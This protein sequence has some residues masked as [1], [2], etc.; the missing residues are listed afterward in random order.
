[1]DAARAARFQRGRDMVALGGLPDN[2]ILGTIQGN[3][4]SNLGPAM[5]RIRSVG[6]QIG[7]V[8]GESLANGITAAV[9]S[10]SISEGFKE[11]GRTMVGGL[12][13]MVR[14]F[15]IQSLKVALLT[16]GFLKSL[17]NLIPG[18]AIVSATAMI[19]LGSAMV[20][21]AG[22]GARAS[23]RTTNTG[24]DRGAAQ[25]STMV[26][27]GTLSANIFGGG[28]ASGSVSSQM[29]SGN[30]V[31]VNATI[32]GYNDPRAQRDIAELMKRSAARG[33]V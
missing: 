24:I 31:M 14:D 1:M 20:G 12:G 27:R 22:R 3:L 16:E 28:M 6:D 19:A 30:P 15:G 2:D 11:L 29:A 9:Q 25:P 23:F 8:L 4:E 33:A 13:A 10:G 21:L 26:E 32:I 18:G 5:D 7:T 17:A